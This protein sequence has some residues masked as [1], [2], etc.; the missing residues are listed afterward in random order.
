MKNMT[1]DNLMLRF[2]KIGQGGIKMEIAGNFFFLF[3]F[4]VALFLIIFYAV[5]FAILEAH[6]EINE[7]GKPAVQ[8]TDDMDKQV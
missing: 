8:Q 5:K 1:T 4:G 2:T 3:I 6:R 7:Q